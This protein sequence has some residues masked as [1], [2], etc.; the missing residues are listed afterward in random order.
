MQLIGHYD[1]PI[2]ELTLASNGTQ[3]TGLWIQQ[4]KY[5]GATLGADFEEKECSLFQQ[6][7]SW[8]DAY[9]YGKNPN[10]TFPLAPA[11]SPFRLAVWNLLLQI[12]YGQVI[13]YGAIARQLEKQTGKRVSAQAVGGAVSHNPISI[14]IPCHRVVGVSGSLT[15]Y[16]AGL[17]KKIQ[18]LQLEGI[19]TEKLL[20]P[21]IKPHDK[22]TNANV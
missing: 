8:L 18:L 20:S 7:N 6:V 1:S 3:L 9:F 21:R 13:T 15:G 12:P 11:G 17:E 16:A 19:A 14:I 10:I 2:G 4:Q 22:Q 5:F